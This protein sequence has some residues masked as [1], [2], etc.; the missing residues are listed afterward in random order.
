MISRRQLLA[1]LAPAP[2]QLNYI[3][4]LADDMGYA[5][6]GQHTPHLNRLAA[7]GVHLTDHY[8]CSPVCSPAR[9][10]LMTGLVPDRVGITGVLRE[11]HDA[12]HGLALSARTVADHFRARGVKR[13]CARSPT[14]SIRREL[15]TGRCFSATPRRRN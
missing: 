2:P 5:D 8:S 14:P 7:D 13:H 3:L 4:V 15:S 11:Q 12:H 1:A 10:G 6:V 9:A